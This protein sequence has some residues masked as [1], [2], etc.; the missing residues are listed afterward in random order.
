MEVRPV[1][2]RPPDSGNLRFRPRA[3]SDNGRRGTSREL[4][5]AP[6][7]RRDC[8]SCGP[9]RVLDQDPAA[10][11]QLI[12]HLTS[13][14]RGG[15]PSPLNLPRPTGVP[16]RPPPTQARHGCA[17]LAELQSGGVPETRT[18]E[19]PPPAVHPL[20]RRSP[21]HG[22]PRP[23]GEA[24]SA[25]SSREHARRSRGRLSPL[26]DCGLRGLEFVER[27][28]PFPSSSCRCARTARTRRHQPPALSTTCTCN[29]SRLAR[30]ARLQRRSSCTNQLQHPG[31]DLADPIVARLVVAQVNQV[32]QAPAQR[33]IAGIL[34]E[35]NPGAR[36]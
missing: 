13:L 15:R 2:G 11:F 34:R 10:G 9:L 31:S 21:A 1:R 6:A 35:V 17:S 19:R 12:T 16:Y 25:A 23:S 26:L 29:P 33:V 3:S 28:L 8:R 24:S 36:L 22:W 5:Q 14:Q 18:A 30:R 4:T 20:W 7:P 32:A 27:L